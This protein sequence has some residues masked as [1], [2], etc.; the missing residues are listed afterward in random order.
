MM[1]LLR[2]GAAAAVAGVAF[3]AAGAHA[4]GTAFGTDE[5][6]QETVPAL[7]EY[8]EEN[9][10]DAAI[11]ALDDPD[12]EFGGHNLG[13]MIWVDGQMGM[14]NRYPELAGVDFDQLQDLEGNYVIE[15]FSAAAD[16]GGDYSLNYWP[17]YDTEEEYEYHCWSEWVEEPRILVAACR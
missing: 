15:D 16:A 14:H 6:I 12:H 11:E 4:D 17:H 8:V 5:D 10:S 2:S 7:I 1:S 13:L 9:G 3:I